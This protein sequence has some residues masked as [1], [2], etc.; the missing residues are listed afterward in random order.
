MSEKIPVEGGL[1]PEELKSPENPLRLEEIS[2][3]QPPSLALHE[4]KVFINDQPLN[5][6]GNEEMDSLKVSPDGR[7]IIAHKNDEE[8]LNKQGYRDSHNSKTVVID[9]NPEKKIAKISRQIPESHFEEDIFKTTGDIVGC[10]KERTENDDVEFHPFINDNQL[11]IKSGRESLSRQEHVIQIHNLQTDEYVLKNTL[12]PNKEYPRIKLTKGIFAVNGVEWPALRYKDVYWGGLKVKLDLE[13]GGLFVR[14]GD[15]NV[16]TFVS[17]NK[18][19]SHKFENAGEYNVKNNRASVL[20]DKALFINDQEWANVNWGKPDRENSSFSHYDVGA[21]GTVAASRYCQSENKNHKSMMEVITGDTKGPDNVWKTRLLLARIKAEAGIVAAVGQDTSGSSLLVINDIP[22]VLMDNVS[23]IIGLDINKEQKVNLRYKNGIGEIVEQN[24][25]L[26]PDSAEILKRN[27]E[28]NQNES[29]LAELKNLIAEQGL[30]PAELLKE[31]AR[32]QKETVDLKN[33]LEGVHGNLIAAEEKFEKFA[34]GTN[35]DLN[36]LKL[37]NTQLE[38]DK[39]ELSKH[40]VDLKALFAKA[41][42]NILSK[43]YTIDSDTVSK[44]NKLLP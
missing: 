44:I 27:E 19:W 17:N 10:V 9:Y 40:R 22:Q 3:Y 26:Q 4:G 30:T 18:E 37:A 42:K 11:G 43:N 25:S 28:K 41:Q 8:Y 12:A 24:F 6:L 16:A 33:K 23:E 14:G 15:K 39:R 38:Q 35:Q 2:R 7:T 36:A 29:A 31:Y 5:D 32:L 13:T 34:S 21:D 20:A 1:K